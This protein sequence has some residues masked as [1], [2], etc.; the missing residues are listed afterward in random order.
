MPSVI[1][2]L[3]VIG[4]RL[5]RQRPCAAAECSPSLGLLLRRAEHSAVQVGAK[6]RRD[7]FPDGRRAGRRQPW[8]N[9][10]R[11]RARRRLARGMHRTTLARTQRR[12]RPPLG[13]P[14]D[15]D[16]GKLADLAPDVPAQDAWFRLEL[17]LALLGLAEQDAEA[18]P[19]KPDAAQSAEQSCAA[20]VFA[21]RQRPGERPD[22][23][24][25][26]PR[27]QQAMRKRQSMALRARTELPQLPAALRDAAMA[28]LLQGVQ[29]AQP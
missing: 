4:M 20:Q 13:A 12:T 22:A 26:G 15:A 17:R 14:A 1:V 18:V 25:S 8:T 29:A 3:R 10:E 5:V 6:A 9:S 2:M 28:Q 24:Y 11:T 16:A 7:G 19:C 21:A 27:E 23:A